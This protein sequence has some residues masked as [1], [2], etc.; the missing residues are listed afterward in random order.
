MSLFDKY[1]IIIIHNNIDTTIIELEELTELPVID[2]D[3]TPF[4][5][6][7]HALL[8][9]LLHCPRPI[10]SYIFEFVNISIMLSCTR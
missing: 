6:K 7:V 2:D 3:F 1:S 4:S 10:V 8:F 9:M 5:S